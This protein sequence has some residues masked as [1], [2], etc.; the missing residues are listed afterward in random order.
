MIIICAWMVKPQTQPHHYQQ[1][2][3]TTISSSNSEEESLPHI[4]QQQPKIY[5]KYIMRTIEWTNVWWR[6]LIHHIRY[7]NNDFFRPSYGNS[8]SWFAHI[9]NDRVFF[10]LNHRSAPIA[11]G[12]KSCLYSMYL[13]AERCLL[14][15]MWKC[16]SWLLKALPSSSSSSCSP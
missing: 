11:L 10:Y 2:Q 3:A 9:T 12:S 6:A 15:L 4:Q 8:L 1:Q 7:T 14:A 13:Y 16:L 5:L